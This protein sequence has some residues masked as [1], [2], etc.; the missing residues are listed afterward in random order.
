MA[1]KMGTV[2]TLEVV[3]EADISYILT[4]GL[5]DIFLHKRQAHGE[6]TAG[7]NVDVFL[8]YDGQKRITATMNIPTIGFKTPGFCKVVDVNKRLGVFLQIGISKDLLLSRD[9]LPFKKSEWPE[10]GDEIFVRLRASRN[11]LTAKIIPRYD[12]PQY[13]KPETELVEKESYTAYV[14]FFGEEG[15]ALTTK[16][17]HG[18]YVYFKYI[19]KN[20]RL[21]QE[22]EVKI[23]NVKPDGTYNGTF[24]QQKELMISEDALFIKKQLETYHGEMMVTDKSDPQVIYEKFHMSKSAFKRAVGSLYRE[25]IIIL[26][27]NSIQLVKPESVEESAE[28]VERNKD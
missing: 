26:T 7:D 27:P 4:D 25:K 8:Y 15:I 24:I 13:L 12:I 20:Y 17:G 22:V 10:V 28:K 23:I 6:L 14:V 9:D 18:I 19:R 3:R 16:E 11:Q 21:G 2:N 1:L 5:E